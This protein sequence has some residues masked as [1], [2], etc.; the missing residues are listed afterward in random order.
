MFQG[1]S[2]RCV[3]AI[4]VLA[5]LAG[6]AWAAKDKNPPLVEAWL[7]RLATA[8]EHLRA[9]DYAKAYEMTD[10][11]EREMLDRIESGPG[12]GALLARTLVTR[13]FA[14]AGLGRMRDATWDWFMARSLYPEIGDDFLSQSGIAG[15]A[16]SEAIA[17]LPSGPTSRQNAAPGGSSSPIPPT[18]LGGDSPQYPY[19]LRDNCVEGT[20]LVSSLIDQQGNLQ[21]PRVLKSPSPLLALATLEALRTWRFKPAELQG[22]PADIDYTVSFN[23]SVDQCRKARKWGRW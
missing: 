9:G 21:R 1:R 11:L 2:F 13:S 19:S 22:Q 8:E 12:V 6:E 17:K 15:E 5:L 18:K 7:G 20:V 10:A 14:A 23:F 3:A 16:V 4:L